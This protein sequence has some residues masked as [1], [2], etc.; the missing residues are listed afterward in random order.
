MP[1]LDR[2]ILGQLAT[3]PGAGGTIINLLDMLSG[4]TI[5]NFSILAMGVY[6]YITAQI[7]LQ[8]LVPIIPALERRM[9]ENP[10]EGQKWMERW[11]VILTVPMA[12]LSAVGQVNIFSS[13][14][15]QPVTS[16]IRGYGDFL[17]TATA[18]VTMIGGT[19]FGIWLGQLISEYGIPNQGL[20]L[21]IFAG[22]V[23]R[24]PSHLGSILSDAVN[25]WW[26]LIVILIILVLTIFAI[27]FV[28]QGRRNVPVLFPAAAS[29]TACQCLSAGTC[30]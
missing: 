30:P 2:N 21:I 5:T 12:L 24:M 10:T 14:L 22:I 29:A 28:Q 17:P 25:G 9:K 4:G 8:L 18:L 27:V 7:I 16:V 13:L 26:I 23:A 20:S 15:N 19:M 6:P 1:G 3:L 11:T